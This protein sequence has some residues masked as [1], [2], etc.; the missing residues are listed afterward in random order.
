MRI[1]IV[2]LA[3]CF[4]QSFCSPANADSF[5]AIKELSGYE[6][7]ITGSAERGEFDLADRYAVAALQLVQKNTGKYQDSLVNLY[8]TRP[9]GDLISNYRRRNS[10]AKAN[11]LNDWLYDTQKKRFGGDS[12]Q[13]MSAIVE[14][15]KTME[16][17]GKVPEAEARYK[18]AIAIAD[19]A[20]FVDS[21]GKLQV[22]VTITSYSAML[23]KRGRADDAQAVLKQMDKFN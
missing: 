15:A 21:M 16:A 20:P 19:K 7:N 1:A 6:K 5:S 2:M 23:Q 10:F 9:V 22:M 4:L 11:Y 17:Q 18:Q 12:L 14:Y 3:L 13:C 8:V